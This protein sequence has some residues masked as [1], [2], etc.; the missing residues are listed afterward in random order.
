MV[1]TQV[2]QFDMESK[3]YDKNF[4]LYLFNKK[5]LI[6]HFWFLLQKGLLGDD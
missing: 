5:Q 2:Y 4:L 6:P 1:A 3:V